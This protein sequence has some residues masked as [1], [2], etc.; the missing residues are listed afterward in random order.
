MAELI[1]M[2]SSFS[3]LKP[4]VLIIIATGII[5]GPGKG[6]FRFLKQ[7]PKL[8]F[9]YTLCNFKA[10]WMKEGEYEFYERA[11]TYG[12]KVHL[13]KQNFPIDPMLISRAIKIRNRCNNSTIQTHG[14]KPN[15]I[16]FFLKRIIKIPWIAFAH[17]YTDE[18][19][20]VKIYNCIDLLVLR[21]ADRVVAVSNSMKKLLV[22]KG[23]RSSKIVVI[24]NVIDKNELIPRKSERDIRTALRIEKKS[25]VI[26]VVGRLEPEKGQIVF[27]KALKKVL[28]KLPHAKA[29]IIGD[30]QERAKLEGY[31]KANV[32]SDN[33][34]FTG[35][36]SNVADYYQIM[37][38]LVIPSFSEGLPNVLLE[39][40]AC[41]IP[42]IATSV[43]GI[44]EVINDKNG[45]L[46]PPGHYIKM[47]DEIMNL[48]GHKKKLERLKIKAQGTVLSYLTPE[49]RAKKIVELYYHLLSEPYPMINKD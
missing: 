45:V 18:N 44:P 41:G 17:G 48:L 30:G 26:G 49:S 23:I 10:S 8:G 14:Y 43:G 38:L 7:A 19:R 16:G 13:I 2:S 46:I 9:D 36:I 27:L 29:L 1:Q 21:Y 22:R 4:N 28:Q 3:S 15:V 24:R 40:M 5:G 42:V 37:D 31:C 32:I 11:V 25:L 34:I 39:A 35:Y 12:I 47:S 20:K 33:V 6:L